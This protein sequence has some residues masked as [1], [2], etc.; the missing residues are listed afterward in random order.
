MAAEF[1]FQLTVTCTLSTECAALSMSRLPPKGNLIAIVEKL[2][3]C[4]GETSGC[5]RLPIFEIRWPGGG[6]HPY[7]S[8]GSKKTKQSKLKGIER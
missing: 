7:R 6:T 4:Y 3:E 2:D 5:E 1:G 8:F